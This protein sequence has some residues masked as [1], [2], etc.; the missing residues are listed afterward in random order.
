MKH[1]FTLLAAVVLPAGMLFGQVSGNT[2][3]QTQDGNDNDAISTQQSSYNTSIQVQ[4]GEGVWGNNNT[5][6][7]L[8]DAVKPWKGYNLAEQYQHGED[9]T[10]D[11]K[12]WGQKNEAYQQQGVGWAK[13][14][15]AQ[16]DQR[17][18]M[19]SAI[20]NQRWDNNFAKSTQKDGYNV[21][22]QTQISG[23]HTASAD[24]SVLNSA[25]IYQEA[26]P[27]GTAHNEAY[28]TQLGLSNT[29]EATQ[30][31]QYNM[32]EQYQVG[33]GNDAMINQLGAGNQA[34]QIQFG[35]DN[36]AEASQSAAAWQG[37]LGMDNY[38]LQHQLGENNFARVMQSGKNHTAKQFQIGNSNKAY[39]SQYNNDNFAD[40]KQKGNGNWAMSQQ[41]GSFNET[42]MK[43]KGKMNY[44][45]ARVVNGK[46]N[47]I[48]VMQKGNG[49]ISTTFLAAGSDENDIDVSQKGKGNTS[50]SKPYYSDDYGIYV[51]GD[52]N[53]V[54][55]D[56]HGKYNDSSQYIVGDSNTATVTQYGMSNIATQTVMG[57]GNNA[58]IY[59]QP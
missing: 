40:I 43:Q 9:N 30:V 4:D 46:L 11:I 38:S 52:L 55:L 18:Y 29:A 54:G 16:I 50:G 42:N 32:A 25:V 44:A 6:S 57:N 10:A 19:N 21:S 59:Q 39:I 13:Y 22:V 26:G 45:F 3:T 35:N 23:L 2:A 20:Q 8:Q 17:N 24:P 1:L 5:A 51:D 36:V 12:Q 41:A 56:Q 28:Q 7:I 47:M 15:D 27:Y 37:G 14:N 31:G 58:T 53:T 34:Y 33:N 48:D 49:N